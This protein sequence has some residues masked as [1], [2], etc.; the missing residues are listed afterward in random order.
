MSN[1]L[2]L[3]HYK[4]KSNRYLVQEVTVAFIMSF[5]I[6]CT[7]KF[8]F[9]SSYHKYIAESVQSKLYNAQVREKHLF[10]IKEL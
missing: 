7:F 6:F 2:F 10:S 1:Q 3:S 4:D 9:F 8:L 5:S